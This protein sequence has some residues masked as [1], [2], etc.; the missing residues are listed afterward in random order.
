MSPHPSICTP[1]RVRAAHA[2][3]PKMAGAREP[4]AAMGRSY[5]L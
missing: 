3:D 5:E 4:V 1:I 2:R